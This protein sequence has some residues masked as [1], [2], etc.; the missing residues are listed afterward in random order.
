LSKKRG[1][2]LGSFGRL[3]WKKNHLGY[4]TFD[5]AACRTNVDYADIAIG[6]RKNGVYSS[7]LLL[8]VGKIVILNDDHVANAQIFCGNLPFVALVELLKVLILPS[9]TELLMERL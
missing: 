5:N 4:W 7:E 1:S 6:S 3:S 9:S 8:T 2:L